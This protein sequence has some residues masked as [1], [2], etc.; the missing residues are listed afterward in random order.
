MLKAASLRSI[1]YSS[2]RSNR[3]QWDDVR[4]EGWELGV[5]LK[6]DR[7]HKE[8]CKLGGPHSTMDSVLASHPAAPGSIL[9]I[10]KDLFIS[11]GSL[12]PR[13]VWSLMLL[14]LIDGSS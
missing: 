2:N 14:R 8:F 1:C 7:V 4:E 3:R 13:E 6:L 9:G 5:N 11:Y 12:I 10:P